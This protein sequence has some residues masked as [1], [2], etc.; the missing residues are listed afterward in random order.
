VNET[1]PL[2]IQFGV[3][4][5]NRV[6]KPESPAFESLRNLVLDDQNDL[7]RRKAMTYRDVLMVSASGGTSGAMAVYPNSSLPSESSAPVQ[8]LCLWFPPFRAGSNLGR[9]AVSVYRCADGTNLLMVDDVTRAVR[10][11]ASRRRPQAVEWQGALW[12]ATGGVIA[13]ANSFFA[14]TGDSGI[15]RIGQYLDQNNAWK[16]A[17]AAGM[18][19]G[20]GQ[21]T[22]GH[23][24]ALEAFQQAKCIGTYRGRVILANFPDDIYG[25]PRRAVLLFSD[26]PGDGFATG[27]ALPTDDVVG[28]GLDVPNFNALNGAAESDPLDDRSV[29]VGDVVEDIVGTKEL[30]LQQSGAM[31]QSA[32]LILKDRSVWLG[33]GEPLISTDVGDPIGS[34]NIIKQPLA[35]GCASFE[36]VAETPWGVFWAGHDD[37][38]FAPNGGGPIIPVGR[39]IASEFKHTPFDMKYLWHAEYHD[40][41]YRLA[42]MAPGQNQSDPVA[43]ENQWWLDLR[44]GPPQD[45]TKAR[46]FGPQMYQPIISPNCDTTDIQRGTYI[47]RR[48]QR[49]EFPAELFALQIGFYSIKDSTGG[50][51]AFIL[52]GLDG[53]EV[54]DWTCEFSPNE[55]VGATETL[56]TTGASMS[57]RRVVVGGAFGQA[58]VGDTIWGHGRIK[59]PFSELTMGTGAG[60]EPNWSNDTSN[61]S[62][63]AATWVD[64]GIIA[65]PSSD[66]DLTA[67]DGSDGAAAGTRGNAILAF[68]KTL[69]MHVGA[70]GLFKQ[71]RTVD[72]VGTVNES[73]RWDIRGRAS[74]LEQADTQRDV[75]REGGH[76]LGYTALDASEQSDIG[77][78]DSDSAFK[79]VLD[80]STKFTVGRTISF[81]LSEVPGFVLSDDDLSFG[82][83]VDANNDGIPETQ[84]TATL[85]EKYYADWAALLTAMCTAMNTACTAAGLFT[86]G[87][88]TANQATVVGYDKKR[89]PRITNVG[90]GMERKW[91]PF[92]ASGSVL[93]AQLSSVWR[94]LGFESY[95]GA[96]AGENYLE[97]TASYSPPARKVGNLRLAAVEATVRLFKRG[98]T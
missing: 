88:F 28:K 48:D 40:G 3:D 23:T 27:A 79:L 14:G 33:T 95:W 77:V 1:L 9:A 45:W 62:D 4:R 69:E 29:F 49:P 83:W 52:A 18:P 7:V 21:A 12:V 6:A 54:R 19:L 90:I 72:L 87:T 36:T 42:I 50:R 86:G 53:S 91:A 70:P 66:A 97:I 93:A 5:H 13:N 35:D 15:I 41:W 68:L 34:L 31:N 11:P 37:V 26:G 51:Y 81:E 75:G 61:T 55:W 92:I 10:M 74:S 2:P 59:G 73:T 17:I 64:A 43:M 46:W 80:T 25:Q 16:I 89:L 20:L 65:V 71:L 67:H 63:G 82:F 38:Y 30:S 60:G 58:G 76:V 8:P 84:G 22:A 47:M 57:L 44:Y 96:T 39:Y 85:T 98:P 94:Q 78:N 56:D 32:L 24:P